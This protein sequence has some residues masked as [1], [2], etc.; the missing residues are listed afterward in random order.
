MPCTFYILYSSVLNKFYI[1]HT[2]EPIEERLRKHLSSHR[3]FTSKAKDWKL[4]YTEQHLNKSIAY[5][6]ELAVK[7]WK[8]R[9]RIE[10]LIPP[11]SQTS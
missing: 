2:C 11:K 5:Q 9:I 1:G 6:R 4:V 7:S 8:S 3:G 10:N